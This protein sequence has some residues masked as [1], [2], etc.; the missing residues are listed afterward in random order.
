MP[1]IVYSVKDP[2]GK[3]IAA[4]LTAKHGFAASEKHKG[5]PCWENQEGIKL[6]ELETDIVDTDYLDEV[7]SADY[8]V[9]ASRHKAA[10]GRPTLTVH[11]TGNWGPSA[12]FGGRPR[13]LSFTRPDKMKLALQYLMENELEGFEVSYEATHH[14]PTIPKTPLLFVEIGSSQDQWV[15]KDAAEVVAG[16][17]MHCIQND[18][19]KQQNAI[20][21]GGIH[22]P[23][24]F[25][26]RALET[27]VALSHM[28]PK[29]MIEEF[30]PEILEQ[31]I[32]KTVGGVDLALVEWKSLKAPQ[33]ERA[34]SILETTGL[35]YERT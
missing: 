12:D 31:A 15:R 28:I 9:M 18:L 7:D 25:T 21:V 14:G 26:K 4:T 33:R 17:I 13:E 20:G 27:N 16:A 34:I 32:R 8:F 22:Y 11:P 29:Y 19:P 35:S 1:T 23:R 10:S 3:N 6:I 24:S 5:R 30:T 2:A